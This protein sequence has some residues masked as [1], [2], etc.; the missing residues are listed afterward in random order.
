MLAGAYKIIDE[1]PSEINSETIE[2]DLTF[3]RLVAMIDPEREEAVVQL[4]KHVMLES[5]QL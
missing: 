2:N 4:K 5:G 1:I 3:A